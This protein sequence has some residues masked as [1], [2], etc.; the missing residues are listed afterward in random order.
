M[1]VW[2]WWLVFLLLL[3]IFLLMS[4]PA[5]ALPKEY[6]ASLKAQYRWMILK[7]PKY[8]MLDSIKPNAPI[9]EG[10]DC[11]RY[12]YLVYNWAAVPGIKRVTAYDMALGKGGWKGYDVDIEDAQE[13]DIIWWT[14]K[15][16]K[17]IHGHVGTIWPWKDGKLV[18]THS[19][20]GRGVVVDKWEK[21]LLSDISKIR[22]ITIGDEK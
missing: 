5:D 4:S 7:H 3:A 11:S 12:L 1:R 17:R 13:L 9:D 20:S 18:I 19:S 22:R 21:K 10:V 14:W 16:S 8:V 6:Q 2:L 15:G